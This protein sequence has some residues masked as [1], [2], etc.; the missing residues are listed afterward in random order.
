MGLAYSTSRIGDWSLGVPVAQGESEYRGWFQPEVVRRLSRP[1][2]GIEENGAFSLSSANLS[3]QDLVKNQLRARRETSLAKGWEAFRQGK[4]QEACSQFGLAGAASADDP[5]VIP[6][7]KMAQFFAQMAAR[8]FSE[9]S[10]T[11]HWLLESDDAIVQWLLADP[12]YGP[13][14]S[15]PTLL[16]QAAEAGSQFGSPQDRHAFIYNQLRPELNQ[17]QQASGDAAQ[18]TI[19]F[20]LHALWLVILWSNPE[21]RSTAAFDARSLANAPAPWNGLPVLMSDALGHEAA[22]SKEGPTHTA[23][24]PFILAPPPQPLGS[25]A[26]PQMQ[27]GSH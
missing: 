15:G 16:D 8:Q 20:E 24:F 26:I 2:D 6:A 5:E 17:R 27:D 12:K 3:L 14:P 13:R 9:A 21:T 7:V 4:Y 23:A 19:S 25:E 1:E 18:A 10:R 22:S 11:L